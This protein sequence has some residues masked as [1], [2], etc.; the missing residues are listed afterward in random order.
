M[1]AQSWQIERM[2]PAGRFWTLPN[3][4]S[5]SRIVLLPLFIWA[6]IVPGHLWLAGVLVG[7]GIVSDLLDGYLA[8]LLNQESEWGRVI[9]PLADKLTVAAALIFCYAA[10]GLPLWVLALV[11]GRDVS[12]LVI[13]PFLANR[14][15]ELPQSNLAGRLAALM[16]GVVAIVYIFS[17]EPLKIPVLA[18]A[19]A[20]LFISSVLYLLRLVRNAH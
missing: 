14:M 6:L 5:L 16:F 10:R 4:L 20:L 3:A 7:W 1:N 11:L 18:A 2:M 15:R 19:T 8:R 13:S 17:V 12:I 9:D